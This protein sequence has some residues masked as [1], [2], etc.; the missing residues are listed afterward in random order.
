MKRISGQKKVIQV[1]EHQYLLLDKTYNGVPFGERYHKSLQSWVVQTEEKFAKLIHRGIKFKQFVGAI[2]VGDLLIEVLPKVDQTQ[3]DNFTK[4]RRFLVELLFQS[5]VFPIHLSTPASVHIH[6]FTLLDWIILAF[7][8]EIKQLLRKGLRRSYNRKEMELPSLKGRLQ[9]HRQILLQYSS[10]EKF[11]AVFNAYDYNSY[12]NSIL[13]KTLELLKGKFLHWKVRQ[14][15][16]DVMRYFPTINSI[17]LQTVPWDRLKE[18]RQAQPYDKALDWARLIW[19][20]CMPNNQLGNHQLFAFLMDMNRLFEQFIYEK[21]KQACP[22]NITLK[23]HYAQTFWKNRLIRPDIILETEGQK[24]II[25]TKWK[26]LK[27]GEPSMEDLR[28]LYVYNQYFGASSGILI[29]PNQNNLSGKVT[30]PIPFSQIVNQKEASTCQVYFAPV[31]E[32]GQLNTLIGKQILW[33]IGWTKR[34][35]EGRRQKS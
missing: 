25:D 3:D 5:K 21:L 11:A 30:N 19:E 33:D 1:Y 20:A 31:V 6:S 24:A 17:D 2:Q 18:D 34:S 23:R 22:E 13:W 10:P 12:Y 14:Q 9:L 15:I 29:Y 28:Q 8:S 7:L 27:R 16:D 32:D 4:W 26:V 35:M